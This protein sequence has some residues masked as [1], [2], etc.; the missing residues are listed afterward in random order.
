MNAAE[1][2]KILKA[3]GEDTR[4]RIFEM[5]R[6]GKLCACK[7]IDNLSITQPTL[8]HH[9]KILCDCGIVIA[10]KDWKWTHYSINCDKLNELLTFLG[11]TRC[12][13]GKICECEKN[14]D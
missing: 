3:L 8:S 14:G 4:I 7:M 13:V 2:A 11:N 9:L 12:R 10:E 5:L 1:C 6:N